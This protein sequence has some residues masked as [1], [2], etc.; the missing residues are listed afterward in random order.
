MENYFLLPDLTYDIERVELEKYIKSYTD[1]FYYGTG[2][3]KIHIGFPERETIIPI[4][5]KFKNPK[6]LFKKIEFNMVKANGIVT[7]HTDHDRFVT[8]NL[9]ICGNFKNSTV[10]FYEKASDSSWGTSKLTDTKTGNSVAVSTAKSYFDAE[11]VNLVSYEVPICFDTQ[12][13]HGVTNST[14]QDRYILALSFKE[15][16]T[17]QRLK[18]MYEYG[19]LL[20]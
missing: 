15:E 16:F 13:I 3:F 6:T 11:L 5:I 1:W 2:R 18:D 8:M 19:D 9:P 4:A 14:D 12:V 17:Y 20:V 7:P 10:D